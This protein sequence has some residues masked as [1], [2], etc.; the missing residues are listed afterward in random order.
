MAQLPLSSLVKKL[1]VDEAA[2]TILAI[3]VT[4]GFPAT[5]F[6]PGGVAAKLLK[7][8][9]QVYAFATQVWYV[10][11]AGGFLDYSEGNWLTLL[12][13]QVYRVPRIEATFAPG[14]ITLTNTS[15]EQ[16]IFRPNDLILGHATS[17]KRYYNTE[18]GTLE[19]AGDPGGGD[20]L[21]LDIRAF[22]SG[23]GSNAIAGAITVMVTSFLGVTC[24]NAAGLVGQSEETD[25]D[26]RQRCRDKLGSLSPNGPKRAYHYFAKSAVRADGSS[27]GVTRVRIPLP[28]GDGTLDVIVASE[29]GAVPGT[30]GD[31]TTDL[32]IV[33]RDIQAYATPIGVT[34]TVLSATN[35]V[36][37]IAADIYVDVEANLTDAEVQ[38]G[39]DTR[40]QAYF[41]TLP[42][43]GQIVGTGK[44]FKNGIEGEIKASLATGVITVDVTTPAA[45]VTIAGTGVPVLGTM[46]WTVHQVT[47]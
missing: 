28:P 2:A 32:G 14:E 7:V 10:I 30:V 1:T 18:G 9:A 36:I 4:I 42:I 45:D 24:T 3:A 26:L 46:I 39:A 29:S 21:T 44:V 31:E 25:P 41:R 27:C 43:A 35:H 16:F 11:A 22:E 15:D 38:A 6:Q 20:V 47:Q 37:N 34:P 12:A 8:A 17:K 33:N 19:P 23:P 5:A 13:F 40:M